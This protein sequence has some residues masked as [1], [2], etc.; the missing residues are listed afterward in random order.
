MPR[1]FAWRDAVLLPYAACA[2]T[3]GDGT[4][5]AEAARGLDRF[6]KVL[7]AFGCGESAYVNFQ[8]RALSGADATR[9]NFGANAARLAAIKHAW[10]PAGATPLRSPQEI[11]V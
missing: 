6:G 7:G 11:T 3:S 10:A 9:L 5:A 1:A 8:D 2:W 4:G